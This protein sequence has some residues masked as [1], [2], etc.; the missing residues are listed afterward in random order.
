[1]MEFAFLTTFGCNVDIAKISTFLK[2]Y[3]NRITEGK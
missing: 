2:D 3:C 1:M